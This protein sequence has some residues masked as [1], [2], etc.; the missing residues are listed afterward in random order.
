MCS[1]ARAAA[2]QYPPQK[3][4]LYVCYYYI[5]KGRTMEERKKNRYEF[6]MPRS[7]VPRWAIYKVWNNIF[8]KIR[9][10]RVT[11]GICISR[12]YTKPASNKIKRK[13][14][15]M[16]NTYRMAEDLISKMASRAWNTRPLRYLRSSERKNIFRNRTFLWNAPSQERTSPRIPLSLSTQW[17]EWTKNVSIEHQP[18][19]W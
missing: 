9:T 6:Y 19:R 10:T 1:R 15:R 17:G 8:F 12:T 18:Q 16:R 11:R 2:I 5:F 3:Q 14:S 13:K 7:S 4:L